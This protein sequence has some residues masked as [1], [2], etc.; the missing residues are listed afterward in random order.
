VEYTAINRKLS[1]IENTKDTTSVLTGSGFVFIL[2]D[3][4]QKKQMLKMPASAIKL[5]I[6]NI[7]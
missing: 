4:Y 7:G 1:G 5:M 2:V 6:S 3:A